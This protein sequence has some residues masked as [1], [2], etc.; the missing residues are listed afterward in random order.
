[1]TLSISRAETV[2]SLQQ[3]LAG[4]GK[5]TC[6][7]CPVADVAKGGSLLLVTFPATAGITAK[8]VRS[9]GDLQVVPDVDDFG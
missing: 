7:D 4:D 3:L 2:L 9:F 8:R 5:A 6:P 1:M